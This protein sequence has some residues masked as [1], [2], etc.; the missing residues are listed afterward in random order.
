LM[1]LW[2]EK[3]KEDGTATAWPEIFETGSGCINLTLFTKKEFD[4][5]AV[6]KSEFCIPLD[7]YNENEN[8]HHQDTILDT[9]IEDSAS[10]RTNIKVNTISAP[11]QN[12]QA[13]AVS[14]L[15]N[16]SKLRHLS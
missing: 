16:K 8:K 5:F 2:K 11:K 15:R 10:S 13:S 7:T 9:I 4:S 1:W 3:G 6:A 12:I 14:R